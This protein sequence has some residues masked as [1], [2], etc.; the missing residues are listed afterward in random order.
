MLISK[1]LYSEHRIIVQLCTEISANYER[2]GEKG[3]QI[4]R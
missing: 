4:N 3:K 2:Y 1:G